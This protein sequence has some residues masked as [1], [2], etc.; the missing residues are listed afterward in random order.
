MKLR[1]ARI[2]GTEQFALL[3]ESGEPVVAILLTGE[4]GERLVLRLAASEQVH[5]ACRAA[6]VQAGMAL[7]HYEFLLNKHAKLRYAAGMAAEAVTRQC[8]ELLQ[9]IPQD[10]PI[11]STRG[12][13]PGSSLADALEAEST[14]LMLD[15]MSGR[16]SGCGCEGCER[17][18]E[19]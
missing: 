16:I 18:V 2:E 19:V 12:T 8:A 11:T 1:P 15:R 7:R 14:A 13:L 4:A 5:E 3:N 6:L 10:S 17:E 9:G